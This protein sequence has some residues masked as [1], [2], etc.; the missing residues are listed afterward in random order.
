MPKLN[1]LL[2]QMKIF[3]T[4]LRFAGYLIAFLFA[5]LLISASILYAN[6]D[7]L[8]VSTKERLAVALKSNVVIEAV[9]LS[10]PLHFPDLALS[11]KNLSITDSA[12][13]SKVFHINKFH[14]DID[15][16]SI[17]KFSPRIKA[18]LIQ[19]A[20]LDLVADSF[21]LLNFSVLNAS[22]D[23]TILNLESKPVS[24]H[25]TIPI[26]KIV[27]KNVAIHLLDTLNHKNIGLKALDVAIELMQKSGETNIDVNGRVYFDGLGFDTRLG[28][29]LKNKTVEAHIQAKIP[30][31][32]EKIYFL[33]SYVVLDAETYNVSGYFKP[34]I[35][36]DVN[37]IIQ[38]DN[39]VVT[40]VL[41]CLSENVAKQIGDYQVSNTVHAII[42]IAGPLFPNQDPSIDLR[43]WSEANN[44]KYKNVPVTVEGINFEGIVC[45]HVNP[46]EKRGDPNTS[47]ELRNVRGKIGFGEL[48]ANIKIND[49]INPTVD[50]NADLHIALADL[51]NSIKGSP[52][53]HLSGNANLNIFYNGK[54]P[55]GKEL[56]LLPEWQ[57]NGYLLFDNIAFKAGGI[58]YENINGKL[59]FRND[60]LSLPKGFSFN[61]AGN[62]VRA[63]GQIYK[64]V[65]HLI[66]PDTLLQAYLKL[67][68]LH[69]DINKLMVKA[70]NQSAV[71]VKKSSKPQKP[72]Q[73]VNSVL[74]NMQFVISL[75]FKEALFRKLKVRNLKGQLKRNGQ[76]MELKNIYFGM[77]GGEIKVNMSA[78]KLDTDQQAG[79]AKVSIRNI[80]V[81]KLFY[82]MD[83]FD[84]MVVTSTNL[85][86]RFDADIVFA[87]QFADGYSIIP[88]SMRG[89]IDFELRNGHLK[90]FEPL[91][92]V[93]K[94]IFR[95]RDFTDISFSKLSQHATL[96]GKK[97]EISELKIESSVITLYV[98][99]TYS[100]DNLVDL[101]I[102]VPWFNLK[103][104]TKYLASL[105]KDPVHA[106]AIHIRAYTKDGKLSFGLGK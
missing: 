100:F 7:K 92:N 54:L 58:Q 51:A 4:I 99:G 98:N 37:I 93:S 74:Q 53:Q 105:Q 45:N 6:K 88:R 35:Y 78:T 20:S 34:D 32:E 63:S 56:S 77:T 83:N 23:T 9:E 75:D 5:L 73:S 96:Y 21:G 24:L 61:I 103:T 70:E 19:D 14:A 46:N 26:D 57:Y 16:F 50:L 102:R 67:Q 31:G 48:L 15:F 69:F 28:Y 8:W 87:T 68:S 59:N 3:A 43:F 91:Q 18:V 1:L 36:P 30:A 84:Q 101:K 94:F 106:R 33:P 11:V 90:N 2:I 12:S 17:L 86:G 97:L 25:F 41:T 42:T 39:A 40:K 72:T 13:G 65:Q 104:N 44:F 85:E 79:S 66:M 95:N 55:A 82:G 52:L 47:F 29:F 60:T 81:K 10:F 71:A 27:L 89:K 22:H 64:P 38:T 62:K 80:D 49:L 76:N